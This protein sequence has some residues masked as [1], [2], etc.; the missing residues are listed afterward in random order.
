MNTTLPFLKYSKLLL[1]LIFSFFL[2]TN[3]SAQNLIT[4]PFS[5]GFV[6]IEGSNTATTAYYLSGNSSS[7][8]LGWSNIQ[9][10]QNSSSN[11]FV[12]L[13]QGND[14]PGMVLITDANGVEHTINGFIKWRTP[15]GNS[16][17]TMVFQPSTGTNVTLETNTTLAPANYTINDTKY[18]GLTFNGSTLV[19]TPIPG[20]VSG[21][22]AT[23]GLLDTLNEYLATFGKL[24]VADVS[25]NEGAGTATVTVTLFDSSANAVTVAYAT[26]NGTATS[27]LDYTATSGTLTFAANQTSTTF[28]IP[29]ID[30]SSIESTETI[31]ITLSD[32]TNASILNGAGVVTIADNDICTITSISVANISVAENAG[33]A[34]FDVQGPN[35]SYV[36][37]YLTN[38]TA[39]GTGVDYGASA[40]QTTLGQTNLEYSI[41]NGATWLIYQNYAQIPGC[42]TLKVRT[43][44]NDD[45]NIEP[46]VTFNLIVKPISVNLG[47]IDLYDVNYNTVNLSSLV[48][49]SGTAEAVNAVY[50]KTNAITVN[51]QAI[52]VQIKIIGKT[53]IGTGA[54]DYL[55]DND[56]TN[57]S[58]FQSEINSSSSSGSFVDYK[59]EFFKSG[60][61]FPVALTNFYITGVD[62]DGNS[63]SSRE[64]IELS[65]FSSY[66]VNNPS[67]L[68]I[69]VSP[70]N[71]QNTRFTGIDNSLSGIT[72]E[73]SASFIANYQSPLTELNFRKGVTGTSNARQFSVAFGAAGGVFTTPVLTSTDDSE[74]AIA[75]IID[76]DSCTVGT[77]AG[78][79]TVQP[80]CAITT[81]TIVFTTQSGVEYSI[82]GTTYQSSATFTGI[83]AGTYTLK[84]RSTSDNTCTATGST[85]TLYDPIC[86]ITDTAGPIN[87]LVGATTA[88]VLTNDTLNG[89]AVIPSAITLTG[90][91]VPTGLTLNPSGTITIAANTPADSYTVT[92]QICEV[93]DPTNC[94]T[95][96][97]TLVVGTCLSFP[98]N[99]CDNDG[100]TNE[101]ETTNG[102]NP[103]DPCLYT[104]APLSAS[105]PYAT[106]SVLDC[107]G[108]G[109]TNQQEVTDGTDPS[110]PDTD[111]DGVT[112]GDEKTDGTDPI[113]PCKFILASQTVAPNVAWENG[114]CDGDGVTNKQEVT[115]GTDPSNP[116]TDGDG[117][118]DGD[119]KTDGTDP[120]DPCKF[121]LASQTVAPNV[122]WENGDCDGDG[123]TNKQEVTDGTDP[124][125]PDTDGDGVTDGD[126]KTDGTDPIDPCKFILASQTV[127]PNV[128]WENGDCDG[129]GVTNKQEKL[130][131]TDPSNPDTDGDG[132][133]DGKEKTDG[134]DPID[135]CKFILASQTVAPNVAWENGDCDG[136]G[137]TNAQEI[138]D[139]T[140]PNNPCESKPEHITNALS[141]SFL[142]GDCDGDGLTNEE[143]IGSNV[144]YPNDPN[145]N[146]IPDY[147]EI[148]NN[149]PSEDD[150]EIFN[151]VTPNGNGEN[152]VFVIRNIQNYPNNTV[153]IF[154]RWGVIVFETEGY[155]QNGKFFKGVSEGRI[156]INKNEE[157]PIGNYFYILRYV[158]NSGVSKERS[159]YLYL[160]K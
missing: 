93:S 44:I 160:N 10:A 159:G 74:I 40:T 117:V 33:Y 55:F 119:E 16:P 106:W 136:D 29:I 142:A 12:G 100:E 13:A 69:G 59:I 37:L 68:A 4:V 85:V 2:S 3:L 137:V 141:A 144:N 94:S 51:S 1:I 135:P 27:G 75:T 45:V 150:L 18:I 113:D 101:L 64:Y 148:N 122:A 6:G 32:P 104:N 130:D 60:T 73:N 78:S 89:V 102:T 158:N 14:I 62:I 61:N 127:A 65:N 5:N 11:Q 118:T 95:T 140:D 124:S 129:D 77:P 147:L 31:N 84:V 7:G 49:E 157:L 98:I 50:K 138:I 97:A 146:G 17:H 19:I 153:T 35:D 133:T 116:D 120:I 121:I 87:G 15:S 63:A 82:D 139:S 42:A 9:F 108:D 39:L 145:G 131:G 79:A 54:S 67:G 76:N 43:P 83:A 149:T 70:T 53:N 88:S 81:G 92:Y 99:D 134:T 34:M 66:T 143:E 21:N 114:D 24:S 126:E 132:V 154:N 71:S 152:D 72:F 57:S 30:D 41:D 46:N 103:N 48:L 26:S 156:T 107:D 38:G 56:G 80:T 58:R 47:A 155:G 109:V 86:A 125:N 111:G 22:A 8:G 91:T 151:A 28:T 36:S 105:T 115:D 23:N 25:V 52:D 20:T 112:D 123:V 96:T 128:A 90:L 110:N